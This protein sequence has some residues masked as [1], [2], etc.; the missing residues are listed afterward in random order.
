MKAYRGWYEGRFWIIDPDGNRVQLKIRG[1]LDA[2]ELTNKFPELDFPAQVR[3][4]VHRHVEHTTSVT[5]HGTWKMRRGA[6][7]GFR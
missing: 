6:P 3:G 7:E 5:H 1:E 4:Y 2:L